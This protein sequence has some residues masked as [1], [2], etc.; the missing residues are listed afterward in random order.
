[1]PKERV[2]SQNL[3]GGVSYYR[4]GKTYHGQE[5]LEVGEGDGALDGDGITGAWDQHKDLKKP[6]KEGKR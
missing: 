5:A 1:M 2:M 6:A 4:D 3:F